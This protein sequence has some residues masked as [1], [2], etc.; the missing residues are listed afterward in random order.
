MLDEFSKKIPWLVVQNSWTVIT[1][2]V[3]FFLTKQ[4]GWE[5]SDECETWYPSICWII[6][7]Y[8]KN[9]TYSSFIIS[10]RNKVEVVKVLYN[11]LESVSN[12]LRW[13]KAR[14]LL[15]DKIEELR[16]EEWKQRKS[17]SNL[18][19]LFNHLENVSGEVNDLFCYFGKMT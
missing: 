14:P 10:T 18:E 7:P 9:T 11:Y 3:N 8:G 13:E 2:E 17:M 1:R 19:F 12:Q 16:K 5:K 4:C 15:Y 6:D